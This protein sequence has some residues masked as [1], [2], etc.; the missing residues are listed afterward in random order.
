MPAHR[1]YGY[2]GAH[3]LKKT[4]TA[5]CLAAVMRHHQNIHRPQSIS[6]KALLPLMLDI[7]GKQDLNPVEP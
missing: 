4:C 2:P 1:H 7:P 6:D 3:C 5:G